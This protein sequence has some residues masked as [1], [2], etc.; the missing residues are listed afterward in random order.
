MGSH[1]VLH[2]TLPGQ[3]SR[4]DVYWIHTV[5]PNIFIDVYVKDY[6]KDIR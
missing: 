1:E 6:V 5:K 2:K 3:I 4:F